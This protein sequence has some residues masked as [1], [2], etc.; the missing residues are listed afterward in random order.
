[1]AT[2]NRQIVVDLP[3]ISLFPLRH[4]HFLFSSR[5]SLFAERV[6]AAVCSLIKVVNEET[7]DSDSH[8]SK[9][10]RYNNKP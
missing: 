1:M 2:L 5:T 9:Y 7:Y 4:D 3:D 8:I 6:A 10:T